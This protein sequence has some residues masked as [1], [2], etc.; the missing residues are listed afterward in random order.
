[1]A[2]IDR[3]TFLGAAGAAT[4]AACAP[5]AT[6]PSGQASPGAQKAE[7]ENEWDRLAAAAR[8]EGKLSVFTL[9][10]A[11]YRKA[12]DGFEK[13]FGIPVE[14]SSE[15]SA[16][17]W[18]TPGGGSEVACY[19]GASSAWGRAVPLGPACAPLGSTSNR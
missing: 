16:S 7:W 18:S 5:A 13:A 1:M 3:R 17:I 14:H 4:A 11:G 19:S 12:L 15:S 9:A 10:G 2:S 6:A 8:Q